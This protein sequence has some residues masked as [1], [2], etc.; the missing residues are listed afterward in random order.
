MLDHEDPDARWMPGLAELAAATG[1]PAT[2][3]TE[4]ER[5]VVSAARW[6]LAAQETRWYGQALLSLMVAMKCLFVPRGHGANKGQRLA[7]RASQ[8]RVLPW[9]DT[10]GQV[11]WLK[12]LYRRRNEA[13][14]EGLSVHE[15]LDVEDLIVLAGQLL[16]WAVWHLDAGHSDLGPCTSMTEV[17]DADRRRD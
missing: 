12:A 8:I 11:A 14:H 10:P 16:P 1:R 13:A 6:V 3:R 17:E 2:E 5:R 9:L 7:E 15:D 4:W